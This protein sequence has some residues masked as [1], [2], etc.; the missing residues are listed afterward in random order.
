MVL[1][2]SDLHVCSSALEIAVQVGPCT[3]VTPENGI[4]H[5]RLY[6]CLLLLHVEQGDVEQA[7]DIH[8]QAGTHPRSSEIRAFPR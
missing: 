8:E 6:D 7:P 1:I 4:T 3:Y 2:L 5:V